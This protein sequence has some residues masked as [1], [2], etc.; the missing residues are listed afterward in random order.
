MQLCAL[1]ALPDEWTGSSGL[2]GTWNL[3]GRQPQPA[4]ISGCT[5]VRVA[6]VGGQI[7]VSQ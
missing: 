6:L 4:C 1:S 7:A 3:E 5:A 2:A